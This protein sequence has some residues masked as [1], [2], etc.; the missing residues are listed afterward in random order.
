[1]ELMDISA[2]GLIYLMAD[3]SQQKYFIVSPYG[4]IV[5]T[6]NKFG[7]KPD[8]YGYAYFAMQFWDDSTVYIIGSKGLKWYDLSGQEIKSTPINPNLLR[9]GGFSNTGDGPIKTATSDGD[10][11]F[12]RGTAPMGKRT[13]NDYFQKKRAITVIDPATFEIEHII[14]LEKDSRLYDGKMYDD[15]DLFTRFSLD[16]SAIYV[17]YDADPALYVYENKAPFTLQYKKDLSLHHINLSSGIDK[18]Y[19]DYD[20][21]AM[22]TDKGGIKGVEVDD[23]YIYLVYFEGITEE[24]STELDKIYDIDEDKGDVAYDEFINKKKSRM[25]IFNK[26]GKELADIELPVIV[27]SFYGF[28][29][30]NGKIYFNKKQNMEEEEDFYTLYIFELESL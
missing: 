24:E 7:D 2:N 16:S 19:I 10:R 29:V 20:M 9:Y 12:A 27:S 30:R 11:I 21:V 3:Y 25:K 22:N 28:I 4:E 8:T 26:S 6:I 15:S 13:D 5:R 14:P 17:S 1:M 23:K 18:K